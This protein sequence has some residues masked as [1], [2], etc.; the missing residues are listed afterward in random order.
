MG[1]VCL[2][3][4]RLG[5]RG[6]SYLVCSVAS[7]FSLLRAKE[8]QAEDRAPA[9]PK[10]TTTRALKNARTA[11]RKHQSRAGS[12][13]G[14]WRGPPSW[15]PGAPRCR[16]G[17]ATPLSP[18]GRQTRGAHARRRRRG[19]A[20]GW[21]WCFLVAGLVWGERGLSHGGIRAMFIAI[22]KRRLPLAPAACPIHPQRT[23]SRGARHRRRSR[24]CSARRGA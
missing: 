20:A 7:F 24:G 6:V 14:R 3:G 11:P 2:K 15:P 17:S 10:T 8:Q 19:A 1:V 9:L 5:W 18:K 16:G 22:P 13:A 23:G 12:R 4:G 21:R